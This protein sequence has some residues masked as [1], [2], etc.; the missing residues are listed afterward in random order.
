MQQRVNLARALALDPQGLLLDE[1]FSALDAQ[2]REFMQEEL[3][4]IWRATQKTALFITHQISEAVYL[5]NRVVVFSARPGRVL[6]DI[7]VPI[8]FPRPLSVKRTP[9]FRAI[10]DHIWSLI[11]DE[12]RKSWK[13]DEAAVGTRHE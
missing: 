2:T 13:L 3:Q 1:P 11:E 9:E 12:F 5:A 4:R 10:E 6:Q 8:P 7:P